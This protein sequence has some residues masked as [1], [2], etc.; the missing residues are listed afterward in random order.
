MPTIEHR[1]S[2]KSGIKEIN[3]RTCMIQIDKNDKYPG[4]SLN[5]AAIIN[6][7]NTNNKKFCHSF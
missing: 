2:P 5:K 4:M 7:P 1:T 3:I 6:L